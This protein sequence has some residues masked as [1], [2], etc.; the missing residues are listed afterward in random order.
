M[1]PDFRRRTPGAA[2]AALALLVPILGAPA[3][4]QGDPPAAPPDTRDTRF[5]L[6]GSTDYTNEIYYLDAL[7]DTTFLK[8]Q[9]F[10]TPQS[11]FAAV[12]LA[13]LSGTRGLR[14]MAYSLTNEVA[15]G[16]LL[17]RAT[18]NGTWQ[19]RFARDWSLFVTPG[20]EYRWDRTLG[21]D[22]E[23]SRAGGTMR[24]RHDWPDR[25]L[26]A[27][28][29]MLGEWLHTTGGDS[30]YLLDRNVAGLLAAIDHTALAGGD[31]RLDYL[32]HVRQ[33][34]DSAARNHFEHDTELHTHWSLPGGSSLELGAEAVRRVTLQPAPSSADNF[35]LGRVGGDLIAL[36]LGRWSWPTHLE[37]ETQRYDVQD[38][39]LYFDYRL[40]RAQTGVRFSPRG[41]WSL[42]IG[43]RAEWLS[44]P[45]NPGESYREFA[46]LVQFD[47]FAS[48]SLWTL[49]GAGG[50]RSF[51]ATSLEDGASVSLHTDYDFVELDL[52]GDQTVARLWR[53]RVLAD[54][55]VE[56]HEE[57]IENG[58]SL[59]FSFDVRRLF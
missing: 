46:G 17:R 41:G 5:E 34:P 1:S 18:L 20:A 58:T 7:V 10:D 28:L 13:A 30:R 12:A 16:D 42:G 43:P 15:Y 54:A 19:S 25:S 49:S 57:P 50:R 24:V 27:E 2:W 22:L 56:R 45:L 37:V 26:G 31:W 29:G 8:P 35:W 21:R 3:W 48:R 59:Y 38:S 32:L 23:E 44:A 51:S 9:R 53:V 47:R 33:F 36:G 52:F 6:G 40:A 55:R 4:A 39:L 11:R 14:T